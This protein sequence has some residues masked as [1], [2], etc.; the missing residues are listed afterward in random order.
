LQN[1]ESFAANNAAGAEVRPG[2]A[3]IIK[4]TNAVKKVMKSIFR[5]ARASPKIGPD[6]TLIFE[7]ELLSIE[8]SSGRKV[9]T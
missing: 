7:V 8:K 3:K 6:S 5:L 4:T 1:S 9:F 2:S